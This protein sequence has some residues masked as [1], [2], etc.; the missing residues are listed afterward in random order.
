MTKWIIIGHEVSG[1]REGGRY[2]WATSIIW[3]TMFPHGWLAGTISQI[4]EWNC[5]DLIA[6]S[7]K[8]AS[9]IR[10]EVPRH[11][12]MLLGKNM[13]TYVKQIVRRK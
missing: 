12:G 2:I 13:L 3:Y 1:T 10:T 11:V 4:K 5:D 7:H 6:G 8:L 9:T